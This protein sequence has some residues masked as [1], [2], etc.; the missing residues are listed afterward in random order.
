M[1][2]KNYNPDDVG[3]ANG[4]LFG[5]PFTYQN[6][7]AI[8]LPV[9][10]DVT[11]SNVGG[12]SRG[13]QAILD[14]S[15]QIDLF[16]KNDKEHWKQGFF[17]KPI[18]KN[19]LD[20]NDYLR[21]KSVEYINFL[22]SGG[23]LKD[24]VS[25][26][27]ILNEINRV[28][29]ELN[30]WVYTETK[31]LLADDK[32]PLVLGGEHSCPLGLMRAIN[33]KYNDWGILQIDAH[34]DLRVAYEGF[35][36]SHAS[37]MHNAMQLKNLTSLVSVG[38]RDYCKQEFEVADENPKIHPFYMDDLVEMELTELKSWKTICETIIWKLPK[39]VYVSFDVDGLDVQYCPN[40]GTPVPGGLQFN[41]AIYL[42]QSIFKANKCII[43]AD[44]C[45]ISTGKYPIIDNAAEINSNIGCRI[46]FNLLNLMIQ[47]NQT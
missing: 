21:S 40:T 22:E 16:N 25:M 17:M 1:E 3:Q 33:E 29:G 31:Q 8:V 6:S 5:L 41:K 46:L 30:D 4:K 39:Y 2:L 15:P 47:T 18:N 34:A 23:K 32:L 13:P 42:L 37:I 19:W 43:A 24:S 38:V 7:K 27:L 10:W 26:T 45:E 36:Y 35:T 20:K 14:Y 12:T 28:G 44:L 11:T 9:P